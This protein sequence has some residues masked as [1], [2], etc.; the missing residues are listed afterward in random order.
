MLDAPPETWRASVV[1]Q[2][3]AGHPALDEGPVRALLQG[4][5]APLPDASIAVIQTQAPAPRLAQWARLGP[6]T[7][8]K[9]DAPALRATLAGA[10]ALSMLS[11]LLSIAAMVR[12]RS[13][14]AA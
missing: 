10:L 3:R 11:A 1:V 13:R 5:L 12:K 4:A 8:A 14:P 2:R 9:R 6:F 7:V